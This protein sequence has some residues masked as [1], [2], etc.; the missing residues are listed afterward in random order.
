M[1]KREVQAAYAAAEHQQIRPTKWG[2][3]L[4]LVLFWMLHLLLLFGEFLARIWKEVKRRLWGWGLSSLLWPPMY[5][6][7]KHSWLGLSVLV[8]CGLGYFAEERE[9]VNQVLDCFGIAL[10]SKKMDD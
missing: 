6:R 5:A 9:K 2:C 4:I 3:L 8:K 10:N 7:I 1:S